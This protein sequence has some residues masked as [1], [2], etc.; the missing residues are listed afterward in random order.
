MLIITPEAKE[1]LIETLKEHTKDPRLAIRIIYHRSKPERL[2]LILDK[3]KKGD[4]IVKS[5]GV[6]VL[7]V[8]ARLASKLDGLCLHYEEILEDFVLSEVTRH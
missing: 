4:L 5:E 6:K 2:D 7:L 1:K 8:H 3:A